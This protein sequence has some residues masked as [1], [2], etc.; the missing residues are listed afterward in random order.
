[1]EW[2]T[3]LAEAVIAGSVAG[4]DVAASD[5]LDHLVCS[6]PHHHHTGSGFLL[7]VLG[8]LS[9]ALE[10]QQMTDVCQC[11]FDV[12]VSD[13]IVLAVLWLI[14][15]IYAV[16]ETNLGDIHLEDVDSLEI[17]ITSILRVLQAIPSPLPVVYSIKVV[18]E[19]Q[20]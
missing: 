14:A 15:V 10:F 8:M 5:P 4:A 7:L 16:Y 3:P 13:V 20:N 2:G 17:T 9:D 19:E 6:P 11:L 1:M 18:Q 12:C